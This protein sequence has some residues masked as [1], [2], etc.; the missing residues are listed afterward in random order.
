MASGGEEEEAL[1][2]VIIVSPVVTVAGVEATGEEEVAME[3]AVD[4]IMALQATVTGGTEQAIYFKHGDYA[5]TYLA[6]LNILSG[7]L[8]LEYFS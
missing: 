6:K 7:Q 5:R 1:E 4:T 8:V 3:V 2:D